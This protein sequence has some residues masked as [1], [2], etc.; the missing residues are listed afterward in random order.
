MSRNTVR[1]Y[2][3]YDSKL[4]VFYWLNLGSDASIYFGTSVRDFRRAGCQSVDVSLKSARLEGDPS[5]L[6]PCD[7]G[8]KHSLHRSGI[9]LNPGPKVSGRVR[10]HMV[11]PE[12]GGDV[13]PLVGILPMEPMVYPTPQRNITST[14]LVLNCDVFNCKPCAFLLYAMRPNAE[15]VNVLIECRESGNYVEARTSLGELKIVAVLYSYPDMFTVWPHSQYEVIARNKEI[16]ASLLFPIFKDIPEN[17]RTNL[18]INPVALRST[19]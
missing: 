14:D 19:V 15:E 6:T 12:S 13:I 5:K 1:I 2:L 8:G 3:K 4:H 9:L 18:T 11:S 17:L 7:I 10:R 16:P